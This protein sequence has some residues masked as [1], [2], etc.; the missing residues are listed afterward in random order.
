VYK[1]GE[2][3]VLRSWGSDMTTGAI[4]STDNVKDAHFSIAGQPDVVL[5]WGAHGATSNRVFFWSN[6]WNIPTAFPLGDTT[7]K[8]VF[9]L[10]SGKTG[11]YDYNITIIP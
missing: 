8:V 3:F 10:E 2:Q 4:L 6:A 1:R 7:V 9:N 11:T 5:N